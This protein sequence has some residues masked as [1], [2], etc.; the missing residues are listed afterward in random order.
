M[1]IIQLN[2]QGYQKIES[3]VEMVYLILKSEDIF[4]K[5]IQCLTPTDLGGIETFSTTI[6]HWQ[7]QRLQ[8]NFYCLPE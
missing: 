1:K 2:S 7:G 6:N 5:E 4:I 3:Q 8:S